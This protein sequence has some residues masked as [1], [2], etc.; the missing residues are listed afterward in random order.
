MEFQMIDIGADGPGHSVRMLVAQAL[1][2]YASPSLHNF[3]RDKND[4]VR[5]A[6]ARELQIRGE[7][8]TL[9]VAKELLVSDTAAH[10]EIGAFTLG[11]LGTP[12]RPFQK[13]CTALLRNALRKEKNVKVRSTI[14][15]SMGQQGEIS[16][17]P[18]G[19]KFFG[20]EAPAVR[21]AVAFA[22]GS[23]GSGDSRVHRQAK[24]ILHGLSK[25]RSRIVREYVKLAYEMLEA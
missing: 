3:L 8:E 19:L 5:T 22:I 1:K 17:L 25:D 6:A 21:A 20:D 13:E 7:R 2:T 16:S 15:T 12:H 14:I 24:K 10:R 4:I 23:T 18:A 11:Q 9:T